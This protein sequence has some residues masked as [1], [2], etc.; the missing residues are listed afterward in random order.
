LLFAGHTGVSTDSDTRIDGFNPFGGHD[1]LWLVMKNLKN[2]LAYPGIV[3]DDTSVF[4]AAVQ[5]G[6]TVLR[7][8]VLLPQPS[9]TDFSRSLAAERNKSRFT[10][11]FPD[12]DG[13]CNCTTWLER[14]GLPLLSGRMNEFTTVMSVAAQTPRRFGLCT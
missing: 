10:Y 3:Y 1:P 8:D 13:D 5:N 11:G 2:R 7:F 9:F 6:L 12:G 14:L 4:T